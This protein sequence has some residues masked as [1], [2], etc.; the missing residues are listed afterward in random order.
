MLAIQ[1][2]AVEHGYT[3]ALNMCGHEA[4]HR[5][6]LNMNVLD[7]V[8]LI[9]SSFGSWMGVDGG[10]RGV[11]TDR[12]GYRYVRLEFDGDRL[13]GGQAVGVTDNIG[14]MRGLIQTG[15]RLGDWKDKLIRA[16]ERLAE[17]YVSTVE[18][19]V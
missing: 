6:S 1:P 10:D 12:D 2:V 19:V 8:G 14:M 15:L 11:S 18:G 13:I 5:G 16:P 9:S 4:R 3:A 7:T 17:A